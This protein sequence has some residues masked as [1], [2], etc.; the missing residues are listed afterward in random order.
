MSEVAG[1]TQDADGIWSGVPEAQHGVDSLRLPDDFRW[2]STCNDCKQPLVM[3]G[4]REEVLGYHCDGC[5]GYPVCSCP[6]KHTGD[7]P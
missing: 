5:F 1:P 3:T 4:G 2:W 6:D 7:C